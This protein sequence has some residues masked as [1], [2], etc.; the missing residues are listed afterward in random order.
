VSDWS[1][2]NAVRYDYLIVLI[3]E[4]IDTDELADSLRNL[5]VSVRSS[6]AYSLVYES[7]RALVFELKKKGRPFKVIEHHYN[8]WAGRPYG[9]TSFPSHSFMN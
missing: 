6:N 1:T 2:R 7:E 8:L 5:A 3:P 9:L 4:E